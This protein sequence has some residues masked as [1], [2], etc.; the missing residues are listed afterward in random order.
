MFKNIGAKIKTLAVV[1]CWIGIV[2]SVVFGIILM[3]LPSYLGGNAGLGIAVLLGGS[4]FSW[5]GCFYTYG[6]GELIEKTTEIA[7]KANNG[8]LTDAQQVKSDYQS[9][10][11]TDR[12]QRLNRLRSQ[13]LI[14]EE[15]F[16]EAVQKGN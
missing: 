7:K 10:L 4:L 2:G 16:R 1:A 14:T 3:A 8:F 9:N 11:E 5:L 13:G 15:E 12:I 6:F